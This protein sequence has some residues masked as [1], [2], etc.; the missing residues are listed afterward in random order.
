[1]NVPQEPPR[2]DF[3]WS[4]PSWYQGV[5]FRSRLEVRWAALFNKLRI[6]WE[7]E[8]RWFTVEPGL[9]YLPDFYLPDFDVF[10]EAKGFMDNVDEKKIKGLAKLL[11]INVVIGYGDYR[12]QMVYINSIEKQASVG[13]PDLRFQDEI[14]LMQCARSKCR[15]RFFR[16]KFFVDDVCPYC[17]E[18]ITNTKSAVKREFPCLHEFIPIK[19]KKSNS[20]RGKRKKKSY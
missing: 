3:K 2:N 12:A 8:K 11:G 17:K 10:F 15:R 7:Y 13:E 16:P 1:M 18:T 9:G 6:R 19:K 14:V 4:K 20:S 5:H